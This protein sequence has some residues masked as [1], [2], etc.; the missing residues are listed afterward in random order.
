MKD[1]KIQEIKGLDTLTNLLKLDLRRNISIR[2]IKGLNNL[3]NL[4][5][6]YIQGYGQLSNIIKELGGV[7]Q[8]SKANE[9]QRF[10]EYCHP[11]KVK[12]RLERKERE[13]LEA[14]RKKR[15]QLEVRRKEEKRLKAERKEKEELA[16]I[17]IKKTILDLGTRFPR[18]QVAEIAEECEIDMDQLIIDI[19]EEMIDNKEIYAKFFK[20]TKSVYFGHIAA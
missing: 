9:P 3:L 15:E 12:E 6:L 18:L 7:D 13:Q 1:N 14:E 11:E 8:D 19:I 5:D 10:V 4:Q 20:S 17:K 2:E 16:K